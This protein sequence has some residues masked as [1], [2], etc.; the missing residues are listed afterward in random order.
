M[1]MIST[2]AFLTEV[3]ASEKQNELVKK[4]V[5]AWEK[6]NS[7]VARAGGVSLM[8]LSL[9]ACGGDDD[10]PFSQVDVDAAKAAATTAAL[11]GADGTVHSS[12]DVAVTSNDTTISA[13]ATTAAESA[14]ADTLAAL[15]ATYDALVVSNTA[16][17]ATY[18][19]L[20]APATKA[21]T[22]SVDTL[23]GTAGNDTFTG[24]AANYA[25]TDQIVDSSTTDADT[26]TLT[27]TAAAT[28]ISTNVETVTV[29]H[30]ALGAGAFNAGSM[31][32]VQVLNY[33][34]GDVVIGG[35]T[36]TG[37]K[38]VN[39]TEVSSSDV[40]KIV[41][42]GSNVTINQE[43]VGTD[44]GVTG[45]VVEATAT[46]D[47]TVEG[48]VDLTATGQ[49]AADSVTVNVLNTAAAGTTV[50][51]EN[52]KAVSIT[53]DAVGAVNAGNGVT[54]GAL[55]GAITV[56]AANVLDVDINNTAGTGVI[57][58]D[59]GASRQT[60][61]TSAAGGAS[62]TSGT[63]GTADATV[64]VAGI[65]SSGATITTGTGVSA[66]SGKNITVTLTGGAAST[67][68]ATVAGDGY[69]SVSNTNVDTLNLSGSTAAV[70]Y[71]MTAGASTITASG[72]H[73]VSLNGD[74]AR[75]TTQ[76][77]T[78]VTDITVT[79]T[80]GTALDLSSAAASGK[81]IASYDIG[82]LLTTSAGQKVELLAD[83]T[84]LDMDVGATATTSDMQII[85]GDE[86]ANSSTVG[87]VTLGA[88]TSDDTDGTAGTLTI[89]AIESNVTAT[90]TDIGSL[91]HIVITG[92]EDVNLGQVTGGAASSLTA[93]DST[94][95]ITLTTTTLLPTVTTGSGADVITVN[96][97]DVHTITTNAGADT[98]TVTDT[99]AT[100][101]IDGGGGDDTLTLTDD[102]TA[103]IALGGAG[104]D[105]F[106]IAANPNMV[107]VGGDGSD[108]TL[109][110][111]GGAALT[112]GATFAMSGI[113]VIELDDVDAIF[114]V[115]A[116]QFAGNNVVKLEGAGGNDTFEVNAAATGSTID[117]SGVTFEATQGVTLVLE[118]AAAADTI[119]GSALN[120]TISSGSAAGNGGGA[121]AYDGGAGTDTFLAAG[122]HA[123]TETGSAAAS[124]G[125]VV[126][127]GATAISGTAVFTKAADYISGGL[128]EVAT[129]TITYTYAADAAGN[130]AT[131]STIVNVE[132]ITGTVGADYIIGG[133]GANTILG[134][135][136]NDFINAGA[137]VDSITT[138]AGNVTVEMSAT[139]TA[140]LAAEVDTITD[141]DT[142]T[143]VLDLTGLTN[144]D[145][146]GTGASYEI[147][148]NSGAVAANTGFIESSSAI[149]NLL[150]ATALTEA[151]TMTGWAANDVVYMFAEDG[152]NG[153]IYKISETTGDTTLD[154]AVLLVNLTGVLDGEIATAN[155][156]DFT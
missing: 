27:I 38:T 150:V 72:A 24:V 80:A 12:V 81:V 156:A 124:T 8:A 14:A 49:G 108:D 62:I 137:G 45:V 33:T 20:I 84:G 122:M 78:G 7:K 35:T 154:E 119:T 147:V 57:T 130:A 43:A 60:D 127:L 115:S 3:D 138:G 65:D 11:T 129:S 132:N 76:T 53:T 113:E 30:N 17:Q 143:N 106:D 70:T 82:A 2:G 111:N 149:A 48:A 63:T 110:A 120:D 131:V 91:Q 95:V 104:D 125:V 73:A 10:T 86:D 128:T 61:V 142:G 26:Y 114:T 31:T 32:G 89:E 29:D 148:A 153:A 109:D 146:R 69:V 15:Q 140:S 19:A 94:G 13:A 98:I 56:N 155:L 136:G 96:G 103:Y 118:G 67:D 9:A 100:S 93:S 101:T 5:G 16:L 46:G 1:N 123:V 135:G 145:L 51:A 64:T 28:P 92:D 88:L 36:L 71:N 47:I 39:I 117:A 126:N 141:F 90:S 55:T 59:A 152:T 144:A 50:A 99:A 41:T 121:D 151:N 58:I 134:N 85:A 6:K 107:I 23:V 54:V 105:H 139:E 18:D 37:D 40:A 42:S 25:D 4:L 97:N 77:I 75:F 79:G 112:A 52:A 34:R 66:A 116:A 74:G 44:G 68:V 22:T 21:L 83:Q 102:D 87:T 133:T